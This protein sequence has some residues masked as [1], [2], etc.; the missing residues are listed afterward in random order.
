MVTD[1]RPFRHT[2]LQ[3]LSV[4]Y[5]TPHLVLLG[6]ALY[7]VYLN[8]AKRG[9]HARNMRRLSPSLS[10][11]YQPF[12]SEQLYIRASYKNIFRAPTF[13]ESYFFHYGSTNLQPE[14]THQLNLGV[15][16][17]GM[18]WNRLDLQMTL[19]GYLN[20]VKD[21]IVAVPYNMFIWTN[22]NLGKV[23]SKGCEFSLRGDYRGD[24]KQN[25]IFVGSYSYQRVSND[26]DKSL[27]DYG[28]Q[29]AYLPLHT[30]SAS[31]KWGNPWVDIVMHG[32]GC[33][34]RW[35]TNSHYEGTQLKAYWDMGLTFSRVFQLRSGQMLLRGDIKNLLNQQYEIV[36]NYPMPGISYQFTIN[37][38]F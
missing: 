9:E 6:R 1:V 34:S 27:P 28:K 23:D 2:F 17:Q 38:K 15:T 18:L 32:A 31:L 16:W 21:K 26:T 33:S 4:K 7:S 19:D 37:Y 24:A 22:V 5:V 36:G 35:A 29:I 11:S 8:D 3:T 30:L 13:N 12:P 14:L 10:M 20:H 25:L